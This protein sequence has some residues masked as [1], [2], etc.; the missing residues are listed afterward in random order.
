MRKIIFRGKTIEGEAWICGDLRQ[1][2]EDVMGIKPCHMPHTTKVVP[3]TV[4]QYTGVNDRNDM[5]IFEGDIVRARIEGTSAYRDFEWPPMKVTFDNGAFG[6]MDA[7]GGFTPFS[8]QMPEFKHCPFCGG[9]DLRIDHEDD[10]D[11]LD[12]KYSKA[13]LHMRCA[14]CDVEMWEHTFD[15]HDYGKRLRLL[16]EKW[17]KRAGA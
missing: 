10:F 8:G 12:E 9:T 16:A 13:S 4:G 14:T 17:N 3:D 15:E 6:I 2:S 5:E 1:Y 7:R 11:F